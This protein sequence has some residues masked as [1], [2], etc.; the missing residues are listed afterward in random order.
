MYMCKHVYN[1]QQN[2]KY[3]YREKSR[4]LISA[5]RICNPTNCFLLFFL[6]FFLFFLFFFLLLM[7]WHIITYLGANYMLTRHIHRPRGQSILINHTHTHIYIYIYSEQTVPVNQTLYPEPEDKTYLFTKYIYTYHPPE[8]KQYLLT[9]HID[10]IYEG[11]TRV[12]TNIIYI[13]IYHPP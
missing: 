7:P 11:K 6:F 8:N 5:G 4:I 9:R 10:H 13:Y 1:F 3:F 12:L 2:I